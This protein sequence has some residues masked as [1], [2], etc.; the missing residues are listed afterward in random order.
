MSDVIYGDVSLACDEVTRIH[1][2]GY[3]I[4]LAKP[5]SSGFNKATLTTTYPTPESRLPLPDILSH[6][7][8]NYSIGV[9]CG[10]SHP[11]PSLFPIDVD[12]DDPSLESFIDRV[13]PNRVPAKRGGKGFTFFLRSS[14]PFVGLRDEI[15]RRLGKKAQIPPGISNDGIGATFKQGAYK[16]DFLANKRN[17]HTIIPPSPYV[18]RAASNSTAPTHYRWYG[19][20]SRSALSLADVSFNNLPILPPSLVFEIYLYCKNP[21][22]AFARLVLEGEDGNFHDLTRDA[23]FYLI[24]EGMVVDEIR[25]L[26]FR[27]RPDKVEDR[28]YLQE[29]NKMLSGA[30]EKIEEINPSAS[31]SKIRPARLYANWLTGMFPSAEMF[32]TESGVTYFW[33]TDTWVILHDPSASDPWLVLK[34][35][36]LNHF[37]DATSNIAEEAIKTYFAMNSDNIEVRKQSPY[38]VFFKNGAYDAR[39]G[40]IR[41]VVKEDLCSE[42]LRYPYDPDC[43]CPM[44]KEFLDDL[45]KSPQGIDA[46]SGPITKAMVEEFLGYS[47]FPSYEFQ[48]MLYVIGAPGTGKS[49]LFKIYE[50]LLPQ[51]W[52]SSVAA[53]N[54]SDPNSARYL[55]SARVN[56]GSEVG[57]K[58]KDIDEK[59]LRI[60]SGE[61]IDIK[62]LYQ[63]VQNITVPARL[64]FHGNMPP[65][66]SDAT[67]AFKRRALIAYTTDRRPTTEDRGLV[68]KI[69][70]EGAGILSYLV[71]AYARLLERGDFNP[72]GYSA[73][74][75]DQIRLESNSVAVWLT[76]TIQDDERGTPS[77]E[78][79]SHYSE[80]CKLNNYR[81]YDSS[82]W[83]RHLN[84]LN[85]RAARKVFKDKGFIKFY[86]LKPINSLFEDDSGSD[87]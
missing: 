48:K 36:L 25:D 67:G 31:A 2:N 24:N 46:E 82:R 8:S 85:H 20:G 7:R 86:R 55:A 49:T 71:R 72:P 53:E 79:Y 78:L 18:S 40:T 60:T 32:K 56:I 52:V 38:L 14:Q 5:D 17:A 76:E 44:W 64:V 34:R 1:D 16:I 75:S 61:R 6:V 33:S 62:S 66:S 83:G 42:V 28:E 12:V 11:L 9:T 10:R 58:S 84:S 54:F 87:A 21:N 68:E 63:N 77:V 59:L 26:M 23:I 19:I 29:L 80:F 30:A 41:P 81:P 39:T 13:L 43:R 65:E 70:R 45:F 4:S 73:L 50:N 47:M 74:V 37:E 15:R 51:N 27:L 69:V 35:A 57:R 3:V 22:S